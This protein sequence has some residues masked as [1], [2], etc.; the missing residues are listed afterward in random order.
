M[1]KTLTE[2][3]NDH[4]NLIITGH[5]GASFEFPENT[6]PAMQKAIEAGCD[7]IEFDLRGTAD[8][9]P[10]LLHDD[11]IDR[12]SDGHGMP[13]EYT[14]AELKNFNFSYFIQDMRREAPFYEHCEIPT[15]E[16]ILSQFRDKVCMNI[17]IYPNSP[18]VLREICRLYQKYDM[19]DHGYLTVDP[20][21]I[22][23]V[24]AFDPQ[25]ELCS[26]RG[27]ETRCLPENL[28][29]SRYEEH[30]RFCQPIRQFCTEETFQ[31]IREYGLR[32]NVFFADTREDLNSLLA[33]GAEGILTNRAHFICKISKELR[34]H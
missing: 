12:T 10:V 30:C 28:H 29:L 11:T 27:W 21:Y 4:D 15:F 26:T 18:E 20:E 1:K 22:E 3:Y 6:I 19:Y 32:G 9:V 31:Q 5:R 33:L 13:E 34:R 24:K 7:M 16:E 23:P 8:G 2:L 17:Q 14:L 25:I